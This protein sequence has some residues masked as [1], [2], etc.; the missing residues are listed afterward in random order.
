MGDGAADD[1]GDDEEK[2]ESEGVAGADEKSVSIGLV[3]SWLSIGSPGPAAVRE[4]RWLWCWLN[5]IFLGST[6]RVD[7]PWVWWW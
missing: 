2:T 6:S 1:R 4:G 3:A 5:D 7:F